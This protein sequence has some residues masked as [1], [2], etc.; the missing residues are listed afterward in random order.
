MEINY[1]EY[2]KEVVEIWFNNDDLRGYSFICS[3]VMRETMASYMDFIWKKI[4]LYIY[5]FIKFVQCLYRNSKEEISNSLLCLNGKTAIVTGGNSGIG[6]A[7]SMLLA[8]RGCRVIIACRRN[9]VK[10]R[11]EIIKRTNNPNIEIKYLDLNR[12]ASVRKFAEEIKTEESKIDY[13]VNNAGIGYTE[14]KTTDDG[15]D[16]VMQCNYFGHFLLTHLLIDLLKASEG[17]R[18]VFLSSTAAFINNLTVERLH[19]WKN[20]VLGCHVSSYVHS[21]ACNIAVAEQMHKKL[22]K[23][24]I[25]TT[26][27]DPGS[28]NTPIFDTFLKGSDTEATLLRFLFHPLGIFLYKDPRIAAESILHVLTSEDVKGG[29]LYFRCKPFH[30]PRNL[31]NKILME[32]IWKETE[33]LVGL[34]PDE[35][36]KMMD[37]L[38]KL[39][40]NIWTIISILIYLFEWSIRWLCRNWRGGISKS[41]ICLS[42]KTAII[43][44]GNSGIGYAT[45]MLL[46]SRGCR[47]IIACRR[48]AEKERD[49]IIKQ[50]NNPNIT[51]KY[52]DL[53]RFT[54]VRKFAEEIKNE[55][56]KIDILIN[57]AGIGY[58]QN[59]T[60]DDGL[61]IVMQTNFFGHFLLTHLLID[62]LK[63]SDVGGRIMF[64]IS[65]ISILHNLSVEALHASKNPSFK[66]LVMSYANSKACNVLFAEKM[67]RK[68]TKYGIKVNSIDPGLVRTPIF[69]TLEGAEGG[70]SLIRTIFRIGNVVISRE[71][72][73]AAEGILHVAASTDIEGGLTYFRCS[74][75]PKPR[76]LDN[77]IVCEELWNESE[78]IVKLSPEEKLARNEQID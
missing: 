60:S 22:E 62:L 74:P 20:Q 58:S 69:D 21:K 51:V 1:F 3:A 4:S 5:L 75:F 26:V 66:S 32:D 39:I 56:T 2:N 78:K 8:S 71:P 33:K 61:D 10:E 13:L 67:N 46:A 70:K 18:I 36:L 9:A 35:K 12:F 43:T 44:G 27:V 63:A 19:P 68:L 30:K 47:V 37:V 53:S 45:S 15:L 59:M 42:G 72:R 57:N 6:Y 40:E 23:F 7:T 17:A 11:D 76:H 64:I 14:D 28:V 65:G 41:A 54:S 29:D 34:R 55:E 77:E 25:V 49:E 48:K 31:D 52:L 38:K 16:P 73:I 50:T 24:G